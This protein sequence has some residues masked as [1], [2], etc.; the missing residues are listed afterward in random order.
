MFKIS[1]EKLCSFFQMIRLKMHSTFL[2]VDVGGG[3]EGAHSGPC[4]ELA[5]NSAAHNTPPQTLKYTYTQ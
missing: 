5:F 3:G 2:W 4:P 1:I